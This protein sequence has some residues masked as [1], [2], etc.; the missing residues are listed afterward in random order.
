MRPSCV[1]CCRCR[2][3]RC[4]SGAKAPGI[5]WVRLCRRSTDLPESGRCE[6]LQVGLEGLVIV[7]QEVA[8]SYLPSPPEA[9][10]EG[11][12][13]ESVRAEVVPGAALRAAALG[14]AMFWVGQGGNA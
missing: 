13:G 10:G 12:R 14:P 2:G 4:T 11:E 7:Q 9:G 1:R 6:G 3:R 8:P 5:V